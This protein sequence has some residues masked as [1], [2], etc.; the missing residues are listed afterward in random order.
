[1]CH[2]K[3]KDCKSQGESIKMSMVLKICQI[4]G[5]Y[6]LC[7]RCSSQP[8][9]DQSSSVLAGA[10]YCDASRTV[11]GLCF[12]LSQIYCKF[13][14][15]LPTWQRSLSDLHGPTSVRLRLR[16]WRQIW[17]QL[18]FWPIHKQ[19]GSISWILTPVTMQLGLCYHKYRM[20]RRGS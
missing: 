19:R 17:F 12:L 6:C 20:G 15:Q 7:G 13:F 16:T 18:Q 4:V 1:M 5:P 2:E 11:L 14:W 8:R 9:K 10:M 3:V